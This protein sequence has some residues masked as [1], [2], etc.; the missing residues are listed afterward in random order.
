[1]ARQ[2]RPAPSLGIGL[3]DPTWSHQRSLSPRQL[4]TG[5]HGTRNAAHDRL[6][7]L[8]PSGGGRTLW[9]QLEEAVAAATVAR[10]DARRASA[11]STTQLDAAFSPHG[12]AAK[13][14]ARAYVAM[15]AR[16][17]ARLA[18]AVEQ[19][20]MVAASAE[21][22]HAAEEAEWCIRLHAQT[23]ALTVQGDANARILRQEV[24]RAEVD[25]SAQHVA[26]S[27]RMADERHRAEMEHERHVRALRDQQELERARSIDEIQKLRQKFE[28]S[29]QDDAAKL[30]AARY[31][32][33]E[34]SQQ[35]RLLQQEQARL[36]H[37]LA[38]ERAGREAERRTI[39]ELHEANRRLRAELSSTGGSLEFT[40]LELHGQIDRLA[41]EK[42]Q[43]AKAYEAELQHVHAMRQRDAAHSHARHEHQRLEHDAAQAALHEQLRVSQA[44]RQA[45]AAHFRLKV[46]R[47]Q[48]LQHAALAAGS[49][50]GRQLLYAESMR[51]PETWRPS[52]LSWR[53]ED[54][55]LSS[56]E[57]SIGAQV[58]HQAG[59]SSRRQQQAAADA[60]DAA[61]AS[62]ADAADAAAVEDISAINESI[63]NIAA[64][65][66]AATAPGAIVGSPTCRSGASSPAASPRS[67]SPV[68]P[69]S[70][71]P[72]RT[73]PTAKPPRQ[74]RNS[75]SWRLAATAAARHGS[76]LAGSPKAH[77]I[78]LRADPTGTPG[79]TFGVGWVDVH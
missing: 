46:E 9:K 68:S 25:L 23:H 15:T 79:L 62:A 35:W 2:P 14:K 70:P 73:K 60:D 28:A 49:V 48:A 3:A 57:R 41:R 50:R 17:I 77:D 78:W 69:V 44:E 63:K 31:A 11:A 24:Q 34:A 71:Q 72:K 51:S 21:S 42:E 1:M 13:A 18:V 10:A 12:Q 32:H 38:D 4:E 65:A 16:L 20:E 55:F 53:G 36:T 27:A 29:A 43:A 59:L 47:L 54:W 39:D 58:G 30:Q 6:G 8:A 5:S 61:A 64:A 33:H 74:P 52:S 7:S 40:R 76:Q 66:A 75:P 37:E 22:A 56:V 67:R 45:D 26:L 19:L